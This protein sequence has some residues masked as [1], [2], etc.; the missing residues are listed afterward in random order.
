MRPSLFGSSRLRRPGEPTSSPSVQLGLTIALGVI[1]GC[2]PQDLRDR[3]VDG[4]DTGVP[5]TGEVELTL[6]NEC[7]DRVEGF[8]VRYP[9]GWHTYEGEVVGPCSLFDP[10]PVE[11]PP[12]SEFPLE[13]AI[14]IAF[15]P[16]TF[17]TVT[18]EVMGRRTI[19]R[20]RTTVD[21]REAAR[22]EGVTTGEGL[23][24]P[25]VRTY[26]YFV[27]LGD[28]TLVAATYEAGTLPFERKRRIL[29]AMMATFDLRAPDRT[30]T[31]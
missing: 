16:V 19:R 30:G 22:V 2:G 10:D 5:I 13:T 21:G 9:G 25:G 7:V 28:T 8:A 1:V 27:D 29:D 23:H 3:P 6:A 12:A 15:E 14:Q 11:V 31:R 17:E 4:T 20:E 24:E 26:E 18:G